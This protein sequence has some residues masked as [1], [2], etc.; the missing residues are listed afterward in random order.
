M[1]VNKYWRKW[2]RRGVGHSDWK[3]YFLFGFIP[4]YIEMLSRAD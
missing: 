4:I 2:N 1:I 3:G